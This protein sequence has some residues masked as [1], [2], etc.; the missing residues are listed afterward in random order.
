MKPTPIER[1]TWACGTCGDAYDEEENAGKCCI[2]RQCRVHPVVEGYVKSRVRLT[3][4]CAVCGLEDRIRLAK[5]IISRETD[6]IA[7]CEELLQA[8]I[9][10]RLLTR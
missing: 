9:S 1:T 5:E 8:E 6:I 4:L 10:K 7:H 2:C 3:S